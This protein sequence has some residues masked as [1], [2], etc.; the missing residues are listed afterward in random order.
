MPLALPNSVRAS[1]MAPASFSESSTPNTVTLPALPLPGVGGS[2]VV[3]P[4]PA[5]VVVA[6]A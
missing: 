1:C 5:A 4:V 3:A 6:P 2:V